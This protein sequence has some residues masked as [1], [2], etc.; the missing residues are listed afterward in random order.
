MER[1]IIG[2]KNI[3]KTQEWSIFLNEFGLQALYLKDF[4]DFADPQET[5][6]TFEENADIKAST[7]AK[8]T[9]NFVFADDGGY[10]I[11]YL[12]GWPGVKSRRI[13][14][15]DKEAT[16][17]QIIDIVLEKMKGV[18][19][20][21]RTVKLTSAAA[22]ADPEGNIIFHEIVSSPGILTDKPG[23]VSMPG[24]PFRSIHFLPDLNKTYAELT[25]AELKSH[26]HKRPVAER[27]AKFLLEYSHA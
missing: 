17:Q 25:E 8:L 26:S 16:D 24:Y 18:P 5:G 2:S 10:E 4:G 9:H 13:L 15:G 21:L 12:G 27:L 6:S 3:A 19:N 7:Y 22:L 11:D 20:E 23:P 1:L 14:P